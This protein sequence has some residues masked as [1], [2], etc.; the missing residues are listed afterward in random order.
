VT[1]DELKDTVLAYLGHWPD[2]DPVLGEHIGSIIETAEGR[3]YTAIRHPQMV[4]REYVL[5][6]SATE[7]DEPPYLTPEDMLEPVSLVGQGRTWEYATQDQV[8]EQIRGGC[9]DAWLWST[10]GRE[11]VFSYPPDTTV[12][13][14]YY[15]RPTALKD[16]GDQ[17]LFTAFPQ[18]FVSGSCAE[19]ARFLREPE[20]IFVS[21]ER[22]FLARLQEVNAAAWSASIPHRQPLKV[23]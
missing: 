20:E 22:D 2:P 10:F 4:A 18:L 19:A 16:G 8:L 14:T 1:Y 6:L 17:P 15:Q 12:V 9:T 5:S 7:D 11:L 21:F 23:R 13:L 3:I